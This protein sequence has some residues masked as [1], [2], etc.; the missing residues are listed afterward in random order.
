MKKFTTREISTIIFEEF[1]KRGWG[2][3]DPS[4]FNPKIVIDEPEDLGDMAGLEEVVKAITDS[5]NNS[6]K[7]D[8]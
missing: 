1:S 4:C 5:I 2:D 6:I 7:N 3:V 8:K